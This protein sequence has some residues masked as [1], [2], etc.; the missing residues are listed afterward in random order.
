M[1]PKSDSKKLFMGIHNI[2]QI[3][4]NVFN[5]ELKLW[6]NKIGL[7]TIEKLTK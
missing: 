5:L 7:R 4:Q 1:K 3:E 6:E 2:L